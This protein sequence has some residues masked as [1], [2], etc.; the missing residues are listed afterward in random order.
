MELMHGRGRLFASIAA[1]LVF[2]VFAKAQDNVRGG[3]EPIVSSIDPSQLTYDILVDG[4]L[5]QDDPGNRKFKTLQAAYAAAP[6]GTE[7]KPTIIGIMPN[8]YK[9]PGGAPRT[10]SMK[11]TKNYIFQE[12][13]YRRDR[14]LD[15]G[16]TDQRMGGLYARVSYRKRS[17]VGRKHGIPQLPV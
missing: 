9:L 16:R 8:V 6:E 13:L 2:G 11:I 5:A 12:C 14:R 15:G 3:I 17:D 10:P 1:L 7:Q 4:N